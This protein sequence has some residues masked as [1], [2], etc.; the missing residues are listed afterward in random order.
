MFDSNNYHKECSFSE[1]I[2][3]YVYGEMSEAENASFTVHISKC[4]DCAEELAGFG[5]VRTEILNW[6]HKEFLPLTTPIIQI[7]YETVTVEAKTSIFAPVWE[8]FSFSQMWLKTATAFAVLAMFAG[9]TF[10][11]FNTNKSVDLAGMVKPITSPTPPIIV[12]VPLT[13]IKPTVAIETEK[14]TSPSIVKNKE[15]EKV[16]TVTTEPKVLKATV[17]TTRVKPARIET[18]QRVTKQNVTLVSNEENIEEDDTLRL[19]D[20]FDEVSTN[21]F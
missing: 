10:S 13:P 1:Q 4:S 18:T 20:L 5:F 21:K 11:V 17:R 6:K 15:A 14:A 9:I 16:K 2:I 8:L 7:P 12:D 19:S 3:S